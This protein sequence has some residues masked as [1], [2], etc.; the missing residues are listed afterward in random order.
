MAEHTPATD[1]GTPT[2]QPPARRRKPPR[3]KNNNPSPPT[4]PTAKKSKTD[5]AIKQAA[6][7]LAAE[8]PPLSEAQRRRIA[9]LFAPA[10]SAV[11]R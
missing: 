10:V 7:R 11:K 5:I 4:D 1:A 2:P 8:A 6:A 3:R 9:E